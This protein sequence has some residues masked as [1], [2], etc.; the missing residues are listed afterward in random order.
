MKTV[1]QIVIVLT[2]FGVIVSLTI[3]ISFIGLFQTIFEPTKYDFSPNLFPK[4]HGDIC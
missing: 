4:N 3:F 1:T 2:I